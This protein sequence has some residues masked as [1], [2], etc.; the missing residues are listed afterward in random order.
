MAEDFAKKLGSRIRHIR[1][2]RGY[3]QES[4]AD[5]VGTSRSHLGKIE[6]GEVQVGTELL[7]KLA[8]SLLVD[9]G[10]FLWGAQTP[11]PRCPPEPQ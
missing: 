8:N 11:L 10:Q 7:Q 3:T 9:I 5:L 6:R 1:R 2:N 4:L